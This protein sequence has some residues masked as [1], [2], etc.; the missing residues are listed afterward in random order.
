MNQTNAAQ[1]VIYFLPFVMLFF[2][3][4]DTIK[5]Q[6][7]DSTKTVYHFSGSALITNNGISVI[8]SFT[9]GKPATIINLNMG[10]QKFSFEPE[11][12]F[13]L[14]G[15]PWSFLFWFR[16]K[17]ANTS[18][19]KF[20]AG[21]H[22]AILFRTVE[23]NVNGVNTNTITG[24][25][26][27]AGELSPNYF[28]T[29]NTSVGAYGLYSK[30]LDPGGN[31]NTL[32]LTLN[33]NFS[34]IALSKQLMLRIAPQVFYLYIDQHHGYYCNANVTIADKRTPFSLSAM[35]NKVITTDIPASQNIVWNTSLTYSFSHLYYRH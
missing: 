5:A 7:K 14:E 27:L 33:A 16:Y 8:P 13:S 28:V 34:N 25:R 17:L 18:K 26:Y 1:R 30:G 22:P 2:L 32:F 10:N 19:F 6:T 23:S 15:K 35:V 21:F 9:L 31:K 24:Q 4:A 29:K 3:M 20:N 12:R 11:F